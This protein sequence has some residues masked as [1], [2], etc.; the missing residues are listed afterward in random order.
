MKRLPALF[1]DRDGVINEDHGYVH[2]ADDFHFIDGIFDLVRHANSSGYAVVVVTN[3]AGIG[4][5][6][7]TEAQ[8]LELS[9]WMRAQFA[10]HQGRIDAVYHCPHHPEFGLGRYRCDCGSR[11][12][13]PGMFLL[14]ARELGLDLERSVMVGDRAS[15]MAA[16]AA[17]GVPTRLLFQG[18]EGRRSEVAGLAQKRILALRDAIPYMPKH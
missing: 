6:L 3:Q 4:R 5:G 11:K 18:G 14:A 8:F 12:P 9:T 16:A 1:L 7:Y 10:A 13:R 15:D 17:A 2:K